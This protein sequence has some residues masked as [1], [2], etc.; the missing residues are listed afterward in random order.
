MLHDACSLVA[1]VLFFGTL[2]AWAI[3]LQMVLR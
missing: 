1:L 3:V 2:M